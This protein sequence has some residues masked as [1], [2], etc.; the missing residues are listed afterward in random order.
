[1]KWGLFSPGLASC[2]GSRA[3][4]LIRSCRSSEGTLL[5]LHT[6][7]ASSF[8]Y[9]GYCI[10]QWSGCLNKNTCAC[11]HFV[12]HC[13]SI[14]FSLEMSL[15]SLHHLNPFHPLL[16]FFTSFLLECR[17]GEQNPSNWPSLLPLESP[18]ESFQYA[19]RLH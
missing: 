7:C 15:W 4:L 8:T 19:V 18:L 2:R 14:H 17:A 12:C 16:K 13:L 10:P 11:I 5:S 1:M 9:S 3:R 6:C